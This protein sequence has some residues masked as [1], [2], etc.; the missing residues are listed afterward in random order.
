MPTQRL[1][2]FVKHLI[3]CSQSEQ[4]SLSLKAEIFKS[5]SLALPHVKEMYGPHWEDCLE[6]L[7]ST[8]RD[9]GGGD[10]GLTV[11][12]SSFRLFGCLESIVKDEESNDDVKDAWS[13]RKTKLSN[14]LAS[15]LW[16]F[17]WFAAH[18]YFHI[19]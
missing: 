3:Q 18:I 13:D 17:G 9:I 8:W 7:L 11:L 12:N 1:I 19:S 4:I 16:K 15:T 2:F 14:V 5:L 10:G 6:V